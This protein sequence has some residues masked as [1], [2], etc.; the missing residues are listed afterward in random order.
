MEYLERFKTITYPRVKPG[1][2]KIGDCG[3]IINIK[4]NTKLFC[5]MVC[6]RLGLEYNYE[7]KNAITNLRKKAYK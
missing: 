5:K 7:H 6:E 4:R 1:T 2:Y 3:T